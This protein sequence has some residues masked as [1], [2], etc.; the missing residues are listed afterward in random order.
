MTSI[1]RTGLRLALAMCA[2]LAHSVSRS[3][4][5]VINSP[6][7]T[8]AIVIKPPRGTLSQRRGPLPKLLLA[9]L[10]LNTGHIILGIAQFFTVC[11][12]TNNLESS[13]SRVTLAADDLD[14]HAGMSVPRD[15]MKLDVTYYDD[16]IEIYVFHAVRV[17]V[18]FERLYAQPTIHCASQQTC[19]PRQSYR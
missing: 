10:L 16:V 19:A 12:Q 3:W 7:T 13:V 4:C 18:A 17:S 15:R 1:F 6:A 9:D 11:Q 5:G 14:A 2:G 8:F